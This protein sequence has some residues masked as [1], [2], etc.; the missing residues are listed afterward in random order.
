MVDALVSV[1][2]ERLLKA[3]VTQSRIVFELKDQFEKLKSELQLM[4]SFLMDADRLKRKHQTLRTIIGSLRELV[5]EAEDILA[6]CE[7]R[8]K[9]EEQFVGR[10]TMCFSPSFS[11]L[12]FLYQTGKRL[13]E[14]NQKVTDI[15]GNISSYL[16]VSFFGQT[17]TIAE[18]QNNQI[19]RWSSSLYQHTQVVGL[20]EHT[21]KIK[22]WIF[23]ANHGLLAVGIVGM[24]GLGKTTTAQRVFNDREV[25]DHFEKRMWVSVSQTFTVEQ[26]M[27]SLLKNLGD[28]SVTDD[29]DELLHKIHQY[30]QGKRYLIV[31]DDVWSKD[32]SWWH[33]VSEGLPRGNGSSVIIT[34]RIE[35]VARKMGVTEERTHS[36][37]LLSEDNSWL[38]FRKIAFA[39]TAGECTHPELAS[40]GKEIVQKCKGLPLAIKAVGGIMLCKSPY[41][42]EWRRIADNFREELVE[43]D[44]S[45]KASLQL[46]YDEL[47]SFLKSCFLCF[48]LYP[49]DSV[50]S[51]E[52]LIHWWIGEGFLPVRN[53]RSALEVGKD[54]FSGLM[55]RC[56]I[57]V[58]DKTYN[59]KIVTCKMHDMVRELAINLAEEDTFS[60]SD[61]L[62]SRHLALKSDIDHRCFQTNL[63][64]RALLSTPKTGEINKV[65]SRVAAKFCECQYLRVLD[66]SKSIFETHLTSLL[67]HIGSLRHLTYLSLSNTHPLIQI[68]R[69]FDQLSNLQILDLSYCQNLKVLPSSITNLRNLIVLDVS[70]CG[71]LECLPKGL[72]RLSNLQ[73]LLGFRPARPDQSK[74]CRISELRT[75]ARLVTLDLQLTHGDAIGDD[76]V[77]VLS[78]LQQLQV[79]TISYFGSHGTDLTQKIN[80]LSPPQQLLELCVKFFPGDMSPSWINPVSLPLLRHLSIS[81]GN[82]AKMNPSFWGNEKNV[83]KV[84]ALM[85]EAMSD[86]QENWTSF[87]LAMPLLRVISISWCPN[88]SSFPIEDVGFRGGVWKKERQRQ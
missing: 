40:V 20:E 12:P 5:Y 3:L 69:S 73:A 49:E 66:L 55:N 61:G 80:K 52:Q 81:S 27:R 79:L 6:D 47:P 64:L 62:K 34:T 74:G 35:E 23:A 1:F 45:V 59:G 43:N 31:M 18:A 26:I 57:E 76:E 48:S 71:S 67:D 32:Y 63:K 78:D 39:D 25:E 42:S 30:L 75:L 85:L 38:L 82:L 65:A 41:L 54:C 44:D 51:K 7:S 88:L 8:S 86:L 14:I 36:P 56:L 17:S 53:G 11:E 29:K 84:E 72:G 77:D 28:G 60:T 21:Q 22:E 33:C 4:Q 68:P 58:V 16:G 83:W 70:H 15:K 87:Q 46:S 10:C 24:G 9:D 50:I 37:K 13:R 2:V 19:S